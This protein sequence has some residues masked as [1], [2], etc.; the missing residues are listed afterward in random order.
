MGWYYVDELTALQQNGIDVLETSQSE[1]PNEICGRC[2]WVESAIDEHQP[3]CW[4]KG[5]HRGTI[6]KFPWWN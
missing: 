4:L 6:V 2:G 5:A 3:A 1:A